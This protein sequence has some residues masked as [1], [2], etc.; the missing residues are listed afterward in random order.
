MSDLNMGPDVSIP[1]KLGQGSGMGDQGNPFG[2]IPETR[3]GPG[4]YT[5]TQDYRI[6]G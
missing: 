1:A 5:V 4:R 6:Q 2:R 3:D